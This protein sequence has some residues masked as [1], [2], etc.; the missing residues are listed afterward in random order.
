MNDTAPSSLSIVLP[1][2]NEAR[3]LV[4]LL[5]ALRETF[6]GAEIILVDDA[7]TDDTAQICETHGI[8]RLHNVQQMGNGASIK[9][10]ARAASGDT[11]VFMD[12]DG[13]HMPQHVV[14][15]L[16]RFAHGDL[17]MLV[18]ARPLAC[19]AGRLRRWGNVAFN[20]LASWMT[21]QRILDLTSGLRVVRARPFREFL[22][23][24]PNGFSYP[25]TSTMAF[26]RSA[27]TVGYE[28]IQ[29]QQRLGSSHLNIWREGVRFLLIIF[30]IGAMYSPLKLFAPISAL[31]FVLATALYGYTYFESGRFTN[32]SA[33][34]YMT[35]LLTF[36]IGMVSEQITS[37]MYAQRDDRR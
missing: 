4:T 7:S 29:V 28:P 36:L 1:A 6:P 31:L 16:E 17:D 27:Y 24:L 25:T 35:S 19:H 13:Q 34:L 10:G 8:R 3:N 33:L 20:L 2:R 11:I 22:H 32:M 30:K 26:L 14:Q 12:A 23:L 37:L 21:H 9:R 15:L 5:P 18:G